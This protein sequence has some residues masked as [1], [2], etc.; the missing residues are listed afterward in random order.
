MTAAE[1]PA[2]VDPEE[3]IEKLPEFERA[4]VELYEAWG[5]GIPPWPRIVQVAAGVARSGRRS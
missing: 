3:V 5:G 4:L 1:A 2:E